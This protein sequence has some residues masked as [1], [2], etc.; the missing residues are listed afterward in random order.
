MFNLH[1]YAKVF[2]DKRFDLGLVI[3]L[4]LGALLFLIPKLIRLLKGPVNNLAPDSNDEEQPQTQD[5]QQAEA[6]AD[7]QQTGVVNIEQ[8]KTETITEQE[9]FVPGG[10]M[11]APA[12]S[13]VSI[14]Y[15]QLAKANEKGFLTNVFRV[16]HG[17]AELV[18]LKLK[19]ALGSG[20][21][22]EPAVPF[23]GNYFAVETRTKDGKIAYAHY[24]PREEMILRSH[25]PQDC[26]D[27]THWD[28]EVDGV[29][30]NSSEW[31]EKVSLVLIGIA[32]FLNFIIAV[33]ALGKIK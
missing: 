12:S 19:E 16:R 2:A 23:K 29:Y 10:P 20:M 9:Q 33:D 13:P 24:E 26:F 8:P 11:A 28:T 31:Q 17:R 7:H 22:R 27:A 21:G 5:Q 32:L 4:I 30:S 15:T 14:Q 6:L 3:A 25:T 18:E 1:E